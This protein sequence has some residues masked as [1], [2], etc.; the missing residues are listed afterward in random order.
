MLQ[1]MTKTKRGALSRARQC[2][3]IDPDTAFCERKQAI[4]QRARQHSIRAGD[5]NR[6]S[7]ERRPS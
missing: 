5:Q 3:D 7:I 1:Q 2:D 6:T 4:H